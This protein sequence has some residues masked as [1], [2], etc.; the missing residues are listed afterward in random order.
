MGTLGG[1]RLPAALTPAGLRSGPG[2]VPAPQLQ[3]SARGR[4]RGLQR[5]GPPVP[6]GQSGGQSG[7]PPG[8]PAGTD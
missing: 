3:T 2:R 8:L 6:A 5:R 7:G 1:W 4:L